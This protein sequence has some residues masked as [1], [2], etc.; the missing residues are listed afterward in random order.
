[1]IKNLSNPFS[2]GGGGVNFEGHVQASFVTLMLTS[3]HAPYLPYWPIV[4]VKLQ[5]KVDGFETDDFIVVV[6]HTGSKE[7]RKLLGQIKHSVS[8]TKGN[9]IF[10]EV[11]QA[12]WSDFQNP[13]IFVRGKEIIALITGFLTKTD[14]EVAWLLDH[15]RANPNDP[16]RFFENIGRANF[17]S[18][19][20]RE[21]LEVFRY[22]LKKANDGVDLTDEAFHAFLK[23]FHLLGYD[24]GEEK[25]VVLSL[26]NSHISQFKPESPRFVWSRILEFTNNRNHHAGHISRRD[27][28]E[29]LTAIFASEPPR[30]IPENFTKP[31]VTNTNWPQHPD[32]TSLA[33]AILIGE[34]RDK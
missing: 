22:H 30:L 13:N 18:K 10:G 12:A 23:S 34:W 27:L 24:L 32:A 28:P 19:V 5:G 15:A 29:E 7:R 4:E 26:I 31:Q 17:S 9:S 3:G 8:I 14:S 33:L 1:M 16:T 6:E 21:K 25:G 11:I 20:K 2:T